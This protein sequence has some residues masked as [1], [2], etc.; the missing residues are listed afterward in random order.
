MSRFKRFVMFA[1]KRTGSNFLQM[2]LN[3]IPGVLCF[4][5]LFNPF[6]IATEGQNSLHGFDMAAREA[7]PMALVALLQT[8]TEDLLGFRLFHDHD[9][10]VIQAVLEDHSCAKIILT[11]NP[12]ESYVSN[13]IA[14]ET[15]LWKMG[16]PK[17]LVS[18]K[19]TFDAHD[20]ERKL[21]NLQDFQVHLMHH[22]QVTG[23]TA[24]YIDYD[25][26]Q[27]VDV[28]NG[29]AAFLGVSGR[30]DAVDNRLKKQNP[31]EIADKVSN[32]AAMEAALARMD[33]FNLA[34]TPNFEPRR[35]PMVPD[36]MAAGGLLYMPIKGCA[37]EAVRRWMRALGPL[38]TDFTQKSLKQWKRATPLHRSFTVLQDPLERADT[39]FRT[40]ILSGA[41]PDVWTVLGKVYD[42]ALPDPGKSFDSD[43]DYRKAL[44]GF[45]RFIKLNLG[46]QTGQKV[47][48]HWASQ[49]T[50]LHGFAQFQT[51]DL[52]LRADRVVEGLEFLAR[53]V[54]QKHPDYAPDPALTPP[55]ETPELRNAARDAYARDYL[56]FGL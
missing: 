46:G 15:G 39:A 29:M 47:D 13:K 6:F 40:R 18:A 24:F 4:G 23:Q 12:V 25:D 16:N 14:W 31:Q 45:L 53:E 56:A 11:R 2:N 38:T 9:P 27:D 36:F 42:V 32:L 33:R 7:D 41:R 34:R 30:V 43:D 22:L 20:F 48:A 19:A 1:E 35:G 49:S 5:E 52:V 55:Y 10:R 51:P 8:K 54:G 28:L 37:D 44:L 50:I 26:I 21:A 17:D 3:A